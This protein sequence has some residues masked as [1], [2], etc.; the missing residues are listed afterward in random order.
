VF[1]WRWAPGHDGTSDIA[2]YNPTT[3]DI[4]IWVIK[5][6]HWASSF[7]IGQ[8][9][10]PGPTSSPPSN[11]RGV[12]SPTAQP[13]VAIGVGDFDHNGVSDIMW[14]DKGTAHI[15]NWLLAYS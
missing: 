6:G 15:D 4:D 8:H 13:V 14:L 5:D 2:W 7:D 10:G 11:D 9:P 3:N 1:G 12:A